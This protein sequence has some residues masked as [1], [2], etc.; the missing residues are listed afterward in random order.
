MSDLEKNFKFNITSNQAQ[1]EHKRIRSE[2][3]NEYCK[4]EIYSSTNHLLISFEKLLDDLVFNTIEDN[5][6]HIDNV[7]Y[8]IGK[9]KGLI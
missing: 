5:K 1:I 4:A 9:I 3:D 6:E 2:K 8:H 7:Y